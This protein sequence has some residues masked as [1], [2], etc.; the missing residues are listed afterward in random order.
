VHEYGIVRGLLSLVDEQVRA[1][2]GR[3]A[4]RVVLGVT[5]ASGPEERLLRDAFEA[6]KTG[7]SAD[8]AELV[9]ERAPAEVCCLG[10]GR[11][12]IAANGRCPRCGSATVLPARAQ[13]ICLKSV[14][15]EV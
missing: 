12:A 1:H 10:C 13:D 6:F 4:V 7:T 5:G 9:L 15:I 2:G 8:E 11:L 3:R 14:E